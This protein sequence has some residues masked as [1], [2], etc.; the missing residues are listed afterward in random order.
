M[1][2]RR[3]L[4]TTGIAAIGAIGLASCADDA[5]TTEAADATGGAGEGFDP[6]IWREKGDPLVAPTGSGPLDGDSVAVKDLFDVEGHRVGAGNEEWLAQA[7][8]ATT[9]APAVAALLA[10]G[11]SVAGISRTDEFAYS[12]AGTNAHYGT[13]PNP[14][15]PDRIPGGSSSGSASAV[16]SGEATIGL[17]TDTG[18]SIRVPSSY[19]GLYGIR[20]THG[21]VSTE[22]L[23]PLAPSFDTVGAMTRSADELESVV[24]VL[25]PEDAAPAPTRAV[26]ADQLLDVADP[27][28]A[29]AMRD[30]VASW[31]VPGLPIEKI[32]FDTADLARWVQ[33]FQIRQGYEAWQA[34]GEWIEGHWESLNPDVQARFETASTRTP[35]DLA[36]ADAVLAE[37]RERIDGALGE[38]SVL[39][40]PSSSSVA[41]PTDSAALGGDVIEDIR[42]R[43]FQ[44]TCLAGITGRPAVSVPLPTDG[45]PMGL[46]LVGARGSDRALASL[47]PLG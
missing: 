24:A 29:T 41:P 12:L 8:P 47:R 19:Q 5:D 14:A 1:T 15:A 23:L 46:C 21:A 34:H 17:G 20:T 40:L 37:A 13:P 45:A 36:E 25:L 43:T 27:D 18:G 30:A 42:A 6:T 32:D 10:A 2:R 33:A 35:D 39:V 9:S 16:A 7:S 3:F 38:D 4:A 22:G 11:A 31:S 28:V 44:L 26:Y